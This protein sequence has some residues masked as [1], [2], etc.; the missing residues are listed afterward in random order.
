M[1]T[2]DEIYR[3]SNDTLATQHPGFRNNYYNS[4]RDASQARRMLGPLKVAQEAEGFNQAQYD[5]MKGRA[6]SQM[7]S[8]AIGGALAIGQGALGILDTSLQAAKIQDTSG[9]ENEVGLLGR[10]GNRNYY[11]FDQLSTDYANT[12]MG[13]DFDYDA[14]RG[15]GGKGVTM[16]KASAV[17]SS[18][19]Q[20]AMTGLQVGGPWGALI[21][22]VVGGGSALAG[23]FAGDSAA[24]SK[25]AALRASADKAANAAQLNFNAGMEQV[26]SL[27]NRKGMVNSVAAGGHI[28]I[29]ESKRGSFTEAAKRHNMTVQQFAKHVLAKTN[30]AK[31]SA[32]MRR[33]ANFARNA[34]K[35]NHNG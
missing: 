12:D 4:F 25:E 5:S 14:I 17:G 8:S 18:A 28:E 1:A 27:N 3:M 21:G 30:A 7:A 24:R 34:S 9:Y 31:Y 20:G 35:W 13:L 19:L 32:A 26:S 2:W 10:A 22:G 6:N 11:D 23:V 15:M 33:K 29:A 16:E